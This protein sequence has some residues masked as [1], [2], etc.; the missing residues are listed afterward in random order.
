MLLFPNP[1]L[2]Q[3]RVADLITDI[4]NR[5]TAILQAPAPQPAPAVPPAF[6]GTA[7]SNGSLRDCAPG[8][9][10]GGGAAGFGQVIGGGMGMGG[11]GGG[12]WLGG[13]SMDG[14]GGHRWGGGGG[15]MAETQ[16]GLSSV[17]QQQEAVESRLVDLIS[18]YTR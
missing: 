10:Q 8:G 11:G 17:E 7:P 18:G 15:G 1:N 2:I 5:L 13:S 16:R 9:M 3:S 12:T 14:G 6:G 4:H